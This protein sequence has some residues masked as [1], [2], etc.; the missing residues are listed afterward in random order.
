MENTTI[1]LFPEDGGKPVINFMFNP[2]TLQMN[3]STENPDNTGANNTGTGSPK[4]SFA[5]KQARI[6][7]LKEV[8]FDH[9]EDGKSVMPDMEKFQEGMTFIEAMKRPPVYRVVWG[10]QQYMRR[11]FIQNFSYQLTKFLPDGTPVRAVVDVTLKEAEDV[12][13]N[14]QVSAGAAS[15]STAQR[16]ASAANTGLTLFGRLFG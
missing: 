2:S 11:C 7:T 5:T 8:I 4:V 14:N 3:S 13:V 12:N 16:F 1:T 6:L 10:T 9:Y 15:P